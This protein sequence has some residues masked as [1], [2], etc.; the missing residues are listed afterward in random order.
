MERYIPNDGYDADASKLVTEF[1]KGPL[2]QR[3]Y[4]S[5][6]RAIIG[7]LV[8]SDAGGATIDISAGSAYDLNGER[9]VLASALLGQAIPLGHNWIKM[10]YAELLTDQLGHPETGVLNYTKA[11]DSYTLLIEDVA[12]LTTDIVL[13]E[14][15]NTAGVLTIDLS[16]RTPGKLSNY[17]AHTGSDGTPKLDGSASLLDGTVPL[18]KLGATVTAKFLDKQSLGG[19][20]MLGPLT[21]PSIV[22]PGYVDGVDVSAHKHLGI[23]GDA[24]QINE[25]GLETDA[26]VTTKIKDLNVTSAKLAA[27]AVITDKILDEAVTFAKLAAD[28]KVFPAEAAFDIQ[29]PLG[30]FD[31]VVQR[32]IGRAGTITKVVIYADVAP[33][34]TDIIIDIRKNGTTIFTNPNN[35]PRVTAGATGP[36]EYTTIDVPAFSANDRFTIDIKQVGTGTTGGESLLVTIIYS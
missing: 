34:V 6:G 24:A 32:M 5:I 9:V 17:H 4:D 27:N 33:L 31:K 3:T 23:A 19:D 2:K 28:A 29:G 18:V 30:V 35:R 21:V 11:E 26:V 22:C 7:G 36:L 20:T 8:I 16:N 14:V 25:N 15:T 10:Q 13:G 12:P 1:Q